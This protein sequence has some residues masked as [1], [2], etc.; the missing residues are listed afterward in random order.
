M[1]AQAGVPRG[2]VDRP[3]VMLD[4]LTRARMVGRPG[5]FRMRQA[6]RAGVQRPDPGLAGAGLYHVIAVEVDHRSG[7]VGAVAFEGAINVDQ[8]WPRAG[9]LRRHVPHRRPDHLHGGK[10]CVRH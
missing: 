3:V 6:P 4:L 8:Q 1:L 9:R 10:L 2:A 5:A 7:T